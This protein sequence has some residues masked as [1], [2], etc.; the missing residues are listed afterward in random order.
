MLDAVEMAN[1]LAV[2]Q[3]KPWHETPTDLYIPPDA[4]RVFLETF[5]GPLDLLLYLIKKNNLDILDIPIASITKQYVA[6]VDVMQELQLELAGDYLLMAAMLAEIKSRLLLPPSPLVDA[7]PVDPRAELVR[8]LQAYEI[9][10]KA[11]IILDELPRQERDSLSTCAVSFEVRSEK[12]L[13]SLQLNELLEALKQVVSQAVL[14][15]R[16]QITF[17]PLS[18]RERMSQVLALLSHGDFV[19]FEQLFTVKEGRMGVVVTFV[20]L[21]EL[22]KQSMIELVQTNLFSPIHIKRT[23]NHE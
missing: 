11:A 2:V 9:F 13:P 17:E 3:G 18:V 21:L 12:V 5:E 7:D 4:L 1:P 10:K 14:N 19:S 6:Y 15:T 22:L 23:I 16:Y 20:A 8:Q